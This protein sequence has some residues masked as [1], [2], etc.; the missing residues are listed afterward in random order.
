MKKGYIFI[1][2]LALSICPQSSVAFA[3][4][5]VISS[6]VVNQMIENFDKPMEMR[7][8]I[9]F[10]YES[11]F[12]SLTIVDSFDQTHRVNR[13]L[14]NQM[15]LQERYLEKDASG[16]AVESYLSISNTVEKRTLMK[17]EEESVRFDDYYRSPFSILKK[18][19]YQQMLSYFTITLQDNF[20]VWKANDYGYG[21]LSNPLLQFYADYDGMVWDSSVTRSILNLT[22]MT[23]Q[24][25]RMS[26]L[27]YDKVK[28]DCFGGI[29]EHHE[30]SV[31]FIEKTPEL[32]PVVGTLSEDVKT[33]YETKMEHFQNLINTGNF[34]QTITL[35]Q[36]TTTLL[37]YDNYYSL[38]VDTESN[39]P[40]A[41]LSSLLLQDASYGNTY[42]G[43]LN[44]SENDTPLFQTFGISPMA[45]YYASIQD[46]TY[47]TLEA[48][49]NYGAISSDF[50]TYNSKTDM[51]VMNL[52]NALYVDQ[53]FSVRLLT[54]LYGV[55]DPCLNNL[56]MYFYQNGSYYLQS[57]VMHFDEAGYLSGTLFYNYSGV[58]LSSSFSFSEM[59]TVDLE[60]VEE[61]KDVVEYLFG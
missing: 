35:K 32:L 43:L 51:Y 33:A 42:V 9:S 25:G 55:L 47:S 40:S 50:L 34:V 56:G 58:V 54:S 41:A 12:P 37:T 48:L 1:S 49:P 46:T 30:I 22:F 38:N 15:T 4:E 23:D 14:V 31:S 36:G 52:S 53:A 45:D 24:N 18:L 6:H 44:V 16:N 7:N 3:D 17:S 60:K 21:A 27:S 8:T 28:K 5:A 26:S 20:Y 29:K 57:L 13:I 2:F 39:K 11:A 59:G 19:S 61:L 10:A